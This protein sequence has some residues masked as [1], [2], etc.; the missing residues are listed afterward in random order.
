MKVRPVPVECTNPFAEAAAG[1][2]AGDGVA[3][4]VGATV[5]QTVSEWERAV[6]SVS[7][8]MSGSGDPMTDDSSPDSTEQGLVSAP[9]GAQWDRLS[10]TVASLV[11]WNLTNE[12]AP[13]T[14]AQ[15]SMGSAA[16][17]AM[18][19]LQGEAATFYSAQGAAAV[20]TGQ[21]AQIAA[22][23]SGQTGALQTHQDHAFRE[24]KTL[25]P[26]GVRSV[27]TSTESVPA[28]ANTDGQ[29]RAATM[30]GA[31]THIASYGPPARL[32]PEIPTSLAAPAKPDLSEVRHQVRPELPG[33][34]PTQA[35]LGLTAQDQGTL[36][37]QAPG[38]QAASAIVGTPRRPTASAAD[39][40]VGA[41]GAT[42]HIASVDTS[43]VQAHKP[44][45][46]PLHPSSAQPPAPLQQDAPGD[47]G[48]APETSQGPPTDSLLARL[49]HAR[50]GAQAFTRQRDPVRPAGQA[51]ISSI[52]GENGTG[53]GGL[54][55]AMS[56]LERDFQMTDSLNDAE[57]ITPDEVI[58]LPLNDPTQ[59]DIDIDDP[60][61]SVRL[62]LSRQAD[63]V[64]IRLATPPEIVEEYR[65]LKQDIESALEDAGMS[66]SDFEATTDSD[67]EERSDREKSG[68]TLSGSKDRESGTD[69]TVKQ[70][71][72][73]NRIV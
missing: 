9:M 8:R 31:A 54:T 39:R 21:A 33:R 61:G 32:N 1:G 42:G 10:Q 5:G 38:V 13:D 22:R 36:R 6:Q 18:S 55:Q 14:L 19:A 71:R 44:V 70:G 26:D 72:L 65:D 27:V 7:G 4:S 25:A 59:I 67:D 41:S 48:S 43:Q 57:T 15:T 62:D 50:A 29:G 23:I 20:T 51:E 45:M 64:A 30:E 47:T 69:E 60:G 46:Q 2:T 58:E 40:L 16:A 37:A 52:G 53:Q 17:E 56:D 49:R 63:E 12:V 11:A 35:R 34:A 24:A 3:G 73:L 28:A 68:R 66:L